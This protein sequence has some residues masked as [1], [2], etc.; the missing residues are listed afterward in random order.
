MAGA[1]AFS[2][3]GSNKGRSGEIRKRSASKIKF[4]FWDILDRQANFG[5]GSR[6]MGGW[7]NRRAAA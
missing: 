2:G 5:R 6:E 3:S 7:E 4:W 1:R